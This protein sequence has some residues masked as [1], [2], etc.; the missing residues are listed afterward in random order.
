MWFLARG[1]AEAGC[2]DRAALQQGLEAVTGEGFSGAQGEITFED[3]DAR[4]PG[5][6]IQ[7]DGAEGVVVPAPGA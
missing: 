2:A 5:V 7:W 6:L 4:V 3:N 1:L